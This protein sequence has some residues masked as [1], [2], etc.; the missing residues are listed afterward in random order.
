M[1]LLVD[2]L[3]SLYLVYTKILFPVQ[4]YTGISYSRLLL[5]DTMLKDDSFRSG[6]ST[7][8]ICDCGLQWETAEHILLHCTLY[9]NQCDDMV[10]QLQQLCWTKKINPHLL[11]TV[12]LYLL[13]MNISANIVWLW[14]KISYSSFYLTSNV[15]CNRHSCFHH[16]DFTTDSSDMN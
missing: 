12:C 4:R 11:H 7:S 3:T 16:K 15:H 13:I 6:T 9:Q 1:N 8:P 2:L 14:S 5:H 10:H